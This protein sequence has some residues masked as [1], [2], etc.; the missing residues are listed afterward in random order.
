MITGRIKKQHLT[1][2]LKKAVEVVT[3]TLENL[4][5]T[6]S[7][8][9]QIF[10]H[11]NTD[12]Y[13]EVKVT[14]VTS[15]VDTNIIPENIKEN[16]SIL[17]VKG[18][19]VGAKYKPKHVSFYCYDGNNLEYEI[20]NVDTSL[21]TSMKSM[22]HMC[23]VS[24]ID[25][26]GWNTSNVTNMEY[27]F[28]TSG[29]TNGQL[30]VG[31][32]DTSNVTKMHYT[33]S[34]CRF[35]RLDLKNLNTS[36]VT[37]MSYTFS[38]TE[39]EYIDLSGWVTNKVTNMYQMFRNSSKLKHLDIRN[40]TFTSVRDYTSIFSGIPNDCLIIVKGETEKNWVKARNSSLTNVKTVAEIGG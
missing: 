17:G 36:N 16:I 11:P 18:T 24:K 26:S 33:F 3:P 8:Q 21:V 14:G 32:I 1:C 35:P 22:F 28:Y 7:K 31:N 40:F 39:A 10:T 23:K 27:M 4:E 34:S 5:V 25:I 37:D 38:Y 2:R 30:I 29:L 19:Y 20:A 15:E 9:E 13:D 6:P 12:G